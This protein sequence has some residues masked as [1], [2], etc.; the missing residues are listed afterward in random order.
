[1]KK[2]GKVV[3]ISLEEHLDLLAL[4]NETVGGSA[5]SSEKENLL[6]R[7]YRKW[8][9]ALPNLE[10]APLFKVLGRRK[11][12]DGV[13]GRTYP[14]TER[15]KDQWANL[16]A[17]IGSEENVR[18]KFDMEKIGLHLHDVVITYR[19]FPERGGLGKVPG[20]SQGG[21]KARC[22]HRDTRY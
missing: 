16:F 14:F 18:L 10:E 21:A 1:M 15:E 8:K 2:K 22:R 19:R 9:H 5:G 20:R 11:E 17:Y 13:D 4:I 7:I 3:P 6:P 12:D